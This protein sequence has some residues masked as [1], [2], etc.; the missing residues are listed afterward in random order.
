MHNLKTQIKGEYN[1]LCQLMSVILKEFLSNQSNENSEITLF[2][3]LNKFLTYIENYFPELHKKALEGY[4]LQKDIWSQDEQIRLEEAL[5]LYSGVKNS[6]DKFSMI[7][8]F[9]ACLIWI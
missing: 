3:G 4:I 8:S 5:K 7:S 9:V 6:K 1:I 2:Q